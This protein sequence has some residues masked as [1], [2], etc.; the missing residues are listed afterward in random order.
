VDWKDVDEATDYQLRATKVAY[1]QRMLRWA[2]NER[3]EKKIAVILGVT[4][5]SKQKQPLTL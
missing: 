1:V 4:R 2:S 5:G 3:T